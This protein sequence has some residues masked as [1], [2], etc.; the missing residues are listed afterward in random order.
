MKGSA[1]TL[2]NMRLLSFSS[3]DYCSIYGQSVVTVLNGSGGGMPG[4]GDG[5]GLYGLWGVAVKVKGR[6]I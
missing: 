5:G 6:A 4:E 2:L 1:K 3:A